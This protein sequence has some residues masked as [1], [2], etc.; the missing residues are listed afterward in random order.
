MIGLGFSHSR[1]AVGLLLSY[2]AGTSLRSRRLIGS[3]SSEQPAK[4]KSEF[5]Y[6]QSLTRL[7]LTIAPDLKSYRKNCSNSGAINLGLVTNKNV[8]LETQS[9]VVKCLSATSCTAMLVTAMSAIYIRVACILVLFSN[10]SCLAYTSYFSCT[11]I[12]S[13]SNEHKE[14]DIYMV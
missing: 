5:V 10:A 6:R 9:N 11:E 4:Q 3:L 1:G 8:V 7:K 13:S 14:R 2:N 12:N